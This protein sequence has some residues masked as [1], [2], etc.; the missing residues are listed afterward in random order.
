M[1]YRDQLIKDALEFAKMVLVAT[2]LFAVSL[3]AMYGVAALLTT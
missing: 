2:L 1:S 3:G